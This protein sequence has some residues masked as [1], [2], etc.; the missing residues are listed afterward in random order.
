MRDPISAN[1]VIERGG[2]DR[3]DA[4]DL[5]DAS[6]RGAF[7]HEVCGQAVDEMPRISTSGASSL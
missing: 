7:E 4:V 5:A 1:E 2:V 6:H 3:A